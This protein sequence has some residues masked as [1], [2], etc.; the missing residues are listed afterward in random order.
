MR[1]G[2]V[3]TGA[4]VLI[5]VGLAAG[6]SC[7]RLMADDAAGL[8]RVAAASNG[9]AAVAMPFLPFGDGTPDGFL[10]GLFAGDGGEASDRL[11]RISSSDGTFTNAVFAS[12]G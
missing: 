10:S 7:F 11:Y 8:M 1:I 9:V 6:G 2:L 3:R 4:N 5:L 12:G